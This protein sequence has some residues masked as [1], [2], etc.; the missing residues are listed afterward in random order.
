VFP[1][2]AIAGL[3]VVMKHTEA[4]NENKQKSE[5]KVEGKEGI[6]SE[7]TVTLHRVTT[8]TNLASC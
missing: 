1:S 3:V 4:S 2:Q 7:P 5:R 6:A 8:K